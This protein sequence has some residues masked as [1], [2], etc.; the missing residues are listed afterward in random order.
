MRMQADTL[1][2]SEQRRYQRL[3]G[4]DRDWPATPVKRTYAILSTPRTG[5]TMLGSALTE[6]GLA[7]SPVEYLSNANLRFFQ[8]IRGPSTLEQIWQDY[9]SRRTTPN[10]YFGTKL[11][12]SQYRAL[13]RQ[14]LSGGKHPD[15][16]RTFDYL[17]FITRRD[18]LNQAISYVLAGE[19]G[20]EWSDTHGERP[21]RFFQPSDVQEIADAIEH[22]K[23]ED[24][25]WRDT[26]R[27][28]KL[29]VLTV[30]YEELATAT[31]ATLRKVFDHLQLPLEP[32]RIPLPR[33]QK[34]PNDVNRA[35]REGYLSATGRHSY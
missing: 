24:A 19:A 11:H 34:L 33:T 1:S 14:T 27:M 10:G 2:P 31:E 4:E 29:P 21:P 13:F 5:S 30:E 3:F 9:Q 17:I 22:L 8:K 18:K 26:I 32:D 6:S 35:L 7:G 12:A 25:Y 16:L 28:L 15:F 23:S 20:G